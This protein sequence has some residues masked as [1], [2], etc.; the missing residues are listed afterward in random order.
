[1]GGTSNT[2]SVAFNNTGSVNV[3]AGTLNLTGGGVCGAGCSGSYNAAASATLSFSG[4][5][6]LSGAMTAP[7]TISF[8]SGTPTLT[9]TY[10]VTGPPA[11]SGGPVTVLP[12]A[13]AATAGLNM[14][15]GLLGG[16][17]NVNVSGLLTWTGGSMTGAGLTNANGGMSIPSGQPVV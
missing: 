17:S 6:S 14:S 7:G 16:A 12:S 15:S 1:T 3:G 4:I 10:N 2:V 9:G 11:V 13:P 5:F 8:P